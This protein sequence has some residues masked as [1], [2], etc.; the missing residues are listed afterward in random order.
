MATWPF[1]GRRR[2]LTRL[3]GLARARGLVIA[4]PAG[5][6]KSRLAAEVLRTLSPAEFAT[7]SI[8]ATRAA[9]DIPY[10]ALAHLLPAQAPAG[11]AN[12]LRWAADAVGSHARGRRLVLSV[13]DAHLLDTASAAVVHHLVRTSRALVVATLRTGEPI[14][15]PDSVVRLWQDELAVREDIGALGI[16]DTGAI[17]S[18]AL[19]GPVDDVTVRR[20]WRATEG[21][22]LLLHEIVIAAVDAGHLRAVRGMWQL[23]ADPPLTARLVE[24]VEER[25]GRLSPDQNAVLEFTALAEPL[26]LA[27]L[28]DLC[29]GT[30]VEEAEEKG[31]IRV[32]VDSRRAVVRLG[33]PI[34]GEVARA[35]CPDLRRRHRYADLAGRLERTGA[36]R[37]EDLLRLTVWRM[38]SGLQAS[39][40]PLLAACRLAWTAHDYPLAIRLGRMAV[41]AGGGV[42]AATLLATVLDYAQLPDEAQ[43]VLAGQDD[44]PADEPARVQLVLARANN[45]AWGMNR[46]DHALRLLDRAE[47]TFTRPESRQEVIARRLNLAASAARPPTALRLGFSL[48][49]APPVTPALRV[50]AQNALALAL[51]Y[52]GRTEEAAGRA[53]EALAEMPQWQHTAPVMVSPLHSTWSLCGFF[54]GDVTTMRRAIDSMEAS[55]AGERGWSRGEG[56]LALA[57]GHLAMLRGEPRTALRALH[58]AAHHE[59]ARTVGGCLGAYAAA[60]ALLGDAPAAQLALDEALSR[61]RPRWTGFMRWVGQT[62]VWIAAASGE[63]SKAADLALTLADECR[64][65]EL[66]GFEYLVL[67]DAVRLGAAGQAA[68]RV[69]DRL[70]ELAAVHDG[71]RVALS[72]DHA[73][74]FA[75]DDGTELYAVAEGFAALDMNLLAAE[76]AAQA[77]A[78]LRRAGDRRATRRAETLASKLAE[79]CQGARTPALKD[80]AAPRLTLRQREI[81]QLAASGL[82]NR[83]IAD[84]LVLSKRTVD[85]HLVAVYDRLGVRDRAGL[86]SLMDAPHDRI[87]D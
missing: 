73:R 3:A 81:A 9:G 72:A 6:G 5:A 68:Q 77:A 87:P 21:N 35:R 2:E 37:R 79:R 69:A 58:A 42:E 18:G 56:S 22:A 74:A 71:A 32:T 16:E 53:Q 34:Y 44:P 62:R 36:R 26:G 80:L 4:G 55:A 82:S 54:A 70:A 40:E 51:C 48:L 43:A 83:E 63:L 61:N 15:P 28:A 52:A 10:G 20:L 66:P 12:P 38:E 30:A 29:P 67:H 45:L 39:P 1:A 75:A 64:D 24:L 76:A 86:A 33:H 50:Q 78:A 8:R 59:T 41:N 13:D 27:D 7:V 84:R 46:L 60:L 47:Q 65:A 85:N 19:G 25:V 49:N 14:G 31:L 17:L 23:V 57:K 11:L